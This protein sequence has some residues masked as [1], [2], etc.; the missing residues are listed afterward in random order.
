[1]HL[2]T[3]TTPSVQSHDNP[4]Y[5]SHNKLSPPLETNNQPLALTCGKN[6]LK[7]SNHVTTCKQQV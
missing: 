6:R 1:M 2:T 5:L 4:N 7:I 3:L